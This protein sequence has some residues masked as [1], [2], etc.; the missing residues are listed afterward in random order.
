MKAATAPWP[1]RPDVRAL[2]PEAIAGV[3]KANGAA[4]ALKEVVEG[5]RLHA[6]VGGRLIGEV[7]LIEFDAPPDEACKAEGGLAYLPVPEAERYQIQLVNACS[8]VLRA[9]LELLRVASSRPSRPSR[10]SRGS[11]VRR[12]G[13]DRYGS[14]PA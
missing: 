5:F 6:D 14:G 3:M 12:A 8:A 7:D 10:S 9:A 11:A 4:A 1:W 2:K 13:R